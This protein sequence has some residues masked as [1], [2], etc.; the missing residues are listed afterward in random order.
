[1]D[2]KKSASNLVWLDLEMTGLDHNSNVIIE[3]AT[4]VTNK[5]LDIIA[6][7]P[8]IA[9]HQPEAKLALMDD[10]CIKTHTNSGLV[11]RVRESKISTEEAEALTLEFIKKWI[12]ERQSPLC[13]NS[14]GTDRRFMYKYM[15]KLENYFHY[16]IIDVS[17]I[18]ELALRWRP[19]IKPYTKRNC[20]L[21]LEDVEDSIEE[22]KYYVSNFIVKNKPEESESKKREDSDYKNITSE[23]DKKNSKKPWA[24]TQEWVDDLIK[25]KLPDRPQD[26]HKHQFGHVVVIGGNLNMAGAIIMAGTSALRVGA[27][28]VSLVTNDAHSVWLNQTH[29]ELMVYGFDNKKDIE[30]LLAKASVIV[31]GPGLGSEHESCE[32]FE[33]TLDCLEKIMSNP[34]SAKKLKS[35]II[36][37]QGL[38]LLSQIYFNRRKLLQSLKDKLIL[39]PHVGE[40][41]ALLSAVTEPISNQEQSIVSAEERIAVVK[42]LSTEYNATV[43]LKGAG[44]LICKGTNIAICT[45]GN[46]GMATAGMGDVLAG[47]TAGLV[48]Q[49]INTFDASCTSVYLHAKAGDIQAQKNGE[50]GLLATDILLEIRRLLNFA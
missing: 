49:D 10:W 35:L 6:T 4:M 12:P 2:H 28:L 17:T 39:T 29:P 42:K 46:P 25:R 5:N 8:V 47:I 7:G 3:I 43:I 26:S 13:G 15:P 38:R 14:I 36:D 22:L 31:L 21:A 27:G 30:Q 24:V 34:Q 11:N 44:S 33:F 9:I 45:L 1:M 32:V 50:R 48:S 18:K 40:A 41:K 37:A 16:R 23:S 19:D 20:H